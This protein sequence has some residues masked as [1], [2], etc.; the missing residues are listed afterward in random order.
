MAKRNYLVEGLSGTGKSTVYDELIRRSY[1]AVSTDRAWSF[2][3]DPDTHLWDRHKAVSELE[4]R[5]PEVVFVCGSSHNRDDFLPYFETVFNLRIDEA[6]MRRRLGRRTEDDWPLGPEGVELMLTLNRS[7]AKPAGAID[8]DAT[9]PLPDVVDDV[10]RLANCSTSGGSWLPPFSRRDSAIGRSFV[11]AESAG[12]TIARSEYGW[13]GDVLMALLPYL[14]EQGIHL[15]QAREGAVFLF[16]P[17]HREQYLARLDPSAF[18]GMA[19]RRYY[20]QLNNS[21]AAGVGYA[22]LDGIAFLRDTL[23]PLR[24]G[25]VAVLIVD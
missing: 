9:R 21:T 15:T 12:E 1:K 4:S 10:L 5:E 16:M 13:S 7:D 24:D 18:D 2:H 22:M 17:T 19:L 20:E 8:V 6:T 23:A 14:D 25:H 11:I 3:P